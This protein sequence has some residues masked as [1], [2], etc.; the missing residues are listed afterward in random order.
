MAPA[1]WRRKRKEKTGD[2]VDDANA[3]GA[4][5]GYD[6]LKPGRREAS[7][8]E[9]VEMTATAGDGLWRVDMENLSTEDWKTQWTMTNEEW[10]LVKKDVKANAK[11]PSDALSGFEDAGLRRVSPDIAA[12]MLRIVADKAKQSKTEREELSGLRRDSRVAHLIGTCVAAAR[13]GSESLSPKSTVSAAWALAVIAGERANSAEMEV[14]AD[15]SSVLIKEMSPRQLADLAWALASCRHASHAVFRAMD[16]SFA[17][18]SAKVRKFSPFDLS[19]LTWAFAHLGA[20]GVGFVHG[21]DVWF[22]NGSVPTDIDASD[23]SAVESLSA[24]AATKAQTFTPHA[25]VATAWGLAVLGGDALRSFSFKTIWAEIGRKGAEFGTDQMS[26]ENNVKYGPWM[27]KHLNQ[28]HQCVVSVDAAGGFEALGLPA[29]PPSLVTASEDA[30][31]KQRRPP[32]TSWYQRD[33]ASILAYMGEKHEEEAFCAG[34]RVDLFVPQWTGTSIPVAIEVDG[35][36]HFARN[37][38]AVKLGQTRLK[39]RQLANLG[40]AVVSVPV[41]DWEYLETSEEKVEYLRC[42]FEAACAAR[43]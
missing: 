30:W 23:E 15:R 22:A 43:K 9:E 18:D 41:A 2:D 21:L 11:G 4:A 33:V 32:V 24:T 13:R 3:R 39:H 20:G 28:I 25:L 7:E 14:L 31:Q 35:P 40:F 17:T 10:N 29:L 6:D 34:Y 12:E 42:G 5:R 16:V 1:N 37:D 26:D 8:S 27:G 19:T 36:S 38:Q